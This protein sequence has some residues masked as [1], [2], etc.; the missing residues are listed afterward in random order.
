MLPHFPKGVSTHGNLVGG[1]N[2]FEK[3]A[4][5][6]GNLHQVR[7]EHKKYL[8]PPPSNGFGVGLSNNPSFIRGSQ[9]CKPPTQTTS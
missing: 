9:E 2:P 4:R 5:Q 6:N 3:Y 7:D 1:F 8:K